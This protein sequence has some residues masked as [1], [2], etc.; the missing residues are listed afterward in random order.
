VGT[1][2]LQQQAD[3]GDQAKKYG[4]IAQELIDDEIE[5]LHLILL[6]L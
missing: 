6:Y 4:L 2:F 1:S 3:Q 5:Y